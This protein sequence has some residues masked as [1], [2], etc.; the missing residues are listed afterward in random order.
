MLT[1]IDL[2]R[3]RGFS[4]LAADLRPVSV[5]LGP[6]SSGKSSV[7]QAVRLACSALGWVL[8]QGPVP[9]LSDDWIVLWW[10]Y[11]VREN[12]AFLPAVD[13]YEL[14][15][16]KGEEPI[17]VTLSFSEEDF[18]QELQVSLR[19][20]QNYAL[21]LDVRVKSSGALEAVEGIKPQSKHISPRLLD[22]LL[23]KEP[24]AVMVPSFYGVIREEPYVNDARLERLLGAGEQGSV[25]RNLIAR[26]GSTKELNDLLLLSVGA[27]LAR[28]TSG[29]G[30]QEAEH[31]AVH[32]RDKNSELEL[33]SAGT[34]LVAL[35]ALF[36]SLKWYQARAAQGRSF[37]FLLDE[38]EAHLHPRLQGDTGARIAELITSFGA[39]VLL[40]TH[41]VEMINRLGE[42]DDAVLIGI[43]RNAPDT[44]I[45][46]SSE[47]KVRDALGLFCDLTPFVGLQLLTT[48]RILFYEGPSDKAILEGSARAYFANDPLKLGK[49]KLWTLAALMGTGNAAA[50]DVLKRALA[51]L[52][53]S[54]GQKPKSADRIKIARVLDRDYHRAP[55][56]G[57]P[58]IDQTANTE[59]MDVVWSRHSIES[60]F[61]DASCL[62]AWLMSAFSGHAKAPSEAD[63]TLWVT[64]AIAAADV[65]PALCTDAA[66]HLAGAWLRQKPLG[67]ASA[68]GA[69]VTAHRDAEAAV[70]KEPA[71]W[72]RGHDRATFVLGQVRDR[73]PLPLQNRVPSTIDNLVRRSKAGGL[74]APSRIIPAEVRAVLDFM[75]Q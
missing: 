45:E 65:D 57:P 61:L 22:A 33:C 35:M 13:M 37:I 44:A 55:S 16:N 67:Q 73:V 29:Q 41:S 64:E 42:R 36:S 71:V 49:F 15:L 53:N 69:Y 8:R 62:S 1:H 59:E 5:L 72:Q 38:P 66:I 28:S 12:E 58:Q 46:L 52:F 7:L 54:P 23:N 75:V 60:L 3:F 6:N 10:D 25:A 27:S 74:M 56:L 4:S 18:I 21:K 26:L 17:V 70:K 24:L 19:Y 43:D 9:K 50:K 48:R 14:F 32:F 20:G 51:P 2:Q 63:L 31:L 11:P 39:Q 34:G 47:S 40:A 30:L 68:D